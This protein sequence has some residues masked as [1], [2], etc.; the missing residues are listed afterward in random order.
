MYL[1]LF[2]SLLSWILFVFTPCAFADQSL[3]DTYLNNISLNNISLNDIP[4]NT[5]TCGTDYHLRNNYTLKV[6][7][8]KIYNIELYA[9]KPLS[10]SEIQSSDIDNMS[11]KITYNY[12][13]SAKRIL[14]ETK[15]EWLHQGLTNEG[16]LNFLETTRV[17]IPDVKKGESIVACKEGAKLILF[18]QAQ[19][20]TRVLGKSNT[21]AFINAFFDI[22][23]GKNTSIP[24]QRNT[25]LHVK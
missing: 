11:L 5:E 20:Q 2:F 9:L 17:L 13:V 4:L 19:K 3:N 23:L 15:K 16:M 6:F 18:H 7:F 14:K 21:L 8:F 1:A 10:G 12:N 25:L 22:W 24:S